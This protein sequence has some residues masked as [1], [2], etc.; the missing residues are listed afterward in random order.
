[1][2]LLEPGSTCAAAFGLPW[3]CDCSVLF[4]FF[5]QLRSL[6]RHAL[7]LHR[8]PRVGNWRPG[9]VLG[10]SRAVT[11]LHVVLD[12]SFISC[13]LLLLLLIKVLL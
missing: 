6:R 11:A 9:W 3:H 5:Q 13:T 12:I 4:I 10:Q 1:M 2:D 7:W 8:Q